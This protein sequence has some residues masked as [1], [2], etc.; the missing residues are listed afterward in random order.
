MAQQAHF[1]RVQTEETLPCTFD[2]QKI[3]E[4]LH[5]IVSVAYRYDLKVK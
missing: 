5:A 4:N 3:R 1:G 2:Q